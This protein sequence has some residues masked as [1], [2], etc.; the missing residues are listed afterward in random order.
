MT[1]PYESTRATD[2]AFPEIVDDADP[3]DGRLPEPQE[4]ALPGDTLLGADKV[5]TTVDEQILGESLDDKLD[6]EIPE[7]PNVTGGS[8]GDPTL[9]GRLV[10]PDEGA[11]TDEEADLVALEA[12][13][14]ADA[15]PEELAMHVVDLNDPDALD[16]ADALDGSGGLDDPDAAQTPDVADDTDTFDGNDAVGDSADDTADGTAGVGQES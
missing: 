16:N 4:P 7:D 8:V 9:A 12:D 5:G 13:P 10:E 15:A 11:H 14:A 6:R 1:S 2:P 3:M